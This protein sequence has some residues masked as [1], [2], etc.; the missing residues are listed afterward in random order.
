MN[1]CPWLTRKFQ[2]YE[3]RLDAC[4]QSGSKGGR[5]ASQQPTENFP[6]ELDTPECRAAWGEW[7]DHKRSKGKGY[8]S[9]KSQEA[10]L[11]QKAKLGAARFCEAVQFSIGC[12]YDGI[13]EPGGNGNGNGK[14]K[15]QFRELPFPEAGI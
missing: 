8:K 9:K 5:I 1:H 6:P 14:K 3:A 11:K 15:F 7:V 12:N 4:R 13:Y 10:M 2:E